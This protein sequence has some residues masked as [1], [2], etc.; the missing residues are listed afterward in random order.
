MKHGN[1]Y[2]VIMMMIQIQFLITF[3]DTNTMFNNFYDDTNTI[4]NNFLN[5]FLRNFYASFPPKKQKLC[6]TPMPG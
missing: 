1:M 6:K 5:T 3:Y 2:L 4:I